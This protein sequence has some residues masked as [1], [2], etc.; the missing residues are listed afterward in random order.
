MSNSVHLLEKK[1]KDVI[2][3]HEIYENVEIVVHSTEKHFVFQ[4][5]LRVSHKGCTY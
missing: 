2:Q 4:I 3:K 5:D 1:I